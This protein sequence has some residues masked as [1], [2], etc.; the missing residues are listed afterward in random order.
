MTPLMDS[1]QASPGAVVLAAGQSRRMGAPKLVLPWGQNTVIE[2]VV[3]SLGEGGIREIVVVT[4]GARE[5][6]EAAL[7]GYPVRFAHNP[8]YAQSEMVTSL[9]IGL[10]ALSP[11]CPALLIAL[12]DQPVI[13]AGV[14]Q[15][16]LAAYR[17]SGSRLVIPSYQMRRGHPWLVARELWPDLLALQPAQSL[18]DFLKAHEDDIQYVNVDTPNVLKDM[19][20]PEDYARLKPG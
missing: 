3:R 13:E 4:G 14:I 20:T 19:D 1:E 7:A 11:G 15:A 5:A 9:Q 10:R 17:S 18:R 2:Q 8:H 12:G 6:V 16:V